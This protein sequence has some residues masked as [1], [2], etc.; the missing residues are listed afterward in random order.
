MALE[1]EDVVHCSVGGEKTLGGSGWLEPLHLSLAPP[2]HLMGVLGS[3][4]RAQALLIMRREAERSP[5]S[6]TG[7]K[8]VGH[9]HLGSKALL[10][11]QFAHQPQRDG[12]VP[13]RLHQQLEDLA[14]GIVGTPQIHPPALDRDIRLIQVPCVRRAR[15]QPT[16]VAG[17][18]RSEL[19]DSSVDRL[20]GDVE[21][22]FGQR[23]LDIAVARSEPK[24]EPYRIPN[25]RR[26]ELLTG[27]G[28]RHHATATRLTPS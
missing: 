10:L 11:Q 4:I 5:G 6:T 18:R 2:H 23:L 12:L 17:I 27:V 24:I 3:V 28:N 22:A 15:S 1:I 26:R 20:I 25:D 21:A 19:V 16:Q 13:P 8:F 7:A 14:L 9:E